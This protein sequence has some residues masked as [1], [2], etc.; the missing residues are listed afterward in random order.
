MTSPAPTEQTTVNVAAAPAP[1]PLNVDPLEVIKSIAANA[2]TDAVTGRFG[3]LP[4]QL[5]ALKAQADANP[6]LVAALEQRVASLEQQIAANPQQA[7]ADAAGIAAL[8]AGHK[9]ALL[10]EFRTLLNAGYQAANPRQ[11]QLI[12]YGVLAFGAIVIV[13]S[14][15]FAA[16]TGGFMRDHVFAA[17]MTGFAIAGLAVDLP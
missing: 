12:R 1:A 13:L 11:R 3:D 4:N 15:I 14:G 7:V 2:A 6:A 5:A 17:V 10:A 9:D 8:L 16:V